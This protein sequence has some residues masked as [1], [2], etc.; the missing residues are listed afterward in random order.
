[1]APLDAGAPV[2]F[3]LRRFTPFL[4]ALAQGAL[5]AFLIRR[6]VWLLKLL[7]ATT[8]G[9]DHVLLTVLLSGFIILL[10]LFILG[11]GE[12]LY[13]RYRFSLFPLILSL[14]GFIVL[15]YTETP[16]AQYLLMAVVVT[17]T[18]L[19]LEV[20]YL[21]WQR[22]DLYQPYSLQ[23]I[24]GYLYLVEIFLFVAALIGV[25][26]LVMIPAWSIT[27]F[28]AAI[29]WLIQI[30]WLRLHQFDLFKATVFALFGTVMATEL[31]VALNLLPSH[32]FMIG[33]VMALFFYAWLGIGRQF[34]LKE[35]D[36][37]QLVTYIVVSSLGSLFTVVSTFWF[38]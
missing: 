9:W 13:S 22:P 25:Q 18:A 36:K 4:C 6:P 15:L 16:T 19:W 10:S 37:P 24:A 14:S 33:S 20:L 1:M 23:K 34:L 21:F 38:T 35:I 31:L 3:L 29:F 7:H 12:P 30:D 2:M 27:L 26:V 11:A 28:A 5:F 32:F 17:F 8:I